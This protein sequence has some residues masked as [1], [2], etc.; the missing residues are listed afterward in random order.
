[1][2][3]IEALHNAEAELKTAG[4]ANARLDAEV[5]LAHILKKDRAWIVTHISD[6]LDEEN[7]RTYKTACNRRAHREPLQYILGTQEFWGLEFIVTPDVLIPRPETELAVEEAIGI[8]K[9]LDHQP[10]IVDLGTGSGCIAI[11]LAKELPSALFFAVDASEKAL[12]VA[13]DNSDK[14]GVSDRI[15]FLRGDLLEPLDE[16]A[17]RGQI[18][19]IVSNPPY[20]RSGERDTLQAEVRDYEPEAALFSGPSGTE[21]HRRIIAEAPTYLR[22]H[23]ALIMEMGMGQAEELREMLSASVAY[24]VPVLTRDLAGIERIVSARKA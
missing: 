19:I 1:L 10:I 4:V 7:S 18:D 17:V 22:L 3:I 16:L 2:T 24:T 21:I 13:R 5:L 20:V 12:A 23:G 14:L 15:Q 11:S 8:A 6:T 9:K